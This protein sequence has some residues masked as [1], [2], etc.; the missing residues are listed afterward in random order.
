M[1]VT[2]NQINNWQPNTGGYTCQISSYQVQRDQGNNTN[3][4]TSDIWTSIKGSPTN[5]T[6]TFALTSSGIVG[7]TT[8]K[9]R[10]RALNKYGWGP[11]GSVVNIRCAK[12]PNQPPSVTTTNSTTYITISWTAPFNN[13]LTITEYKIEIKKKSGAGY[14]TTSECD[15]KNA[16]VFS[17]MSC[18]I[19]MTTLRGTTTYNYT[20]KDIPIF[21]V[22]A[23][24][25]EGF[26]TGT[27][28]TVGAT[29]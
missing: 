29:I 20:Y 7:G 3:N 5:D 23:Y 6:N 14:G 15:G 19:Q 12:A 11:W 16:P 24:N 27:E 10:V 21:R 13:G 18:N 25:L 4:A 1:R 26:G 22:S 28:N 17:S 9:V 2:F 8:Y